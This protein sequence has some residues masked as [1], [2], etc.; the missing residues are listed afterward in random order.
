MARSRKDRQET[1]AALLGT[2]PPPPR[3]EPDPSPVEA[4]TPA[5]VEPTAVEEAEPAQV[6]E[7]PQVTVEPPRS[8]PKRQR[9][10][11]PEPAPLVAPGKVR[12]LQVR[13][14]AR[15]FE[16][17]REAKDEAGD[18]HEVFFLDALDAVFDELGEHYKP[19]PV[20]RTR[21]P[22]RQRRTRRP[23]TDPLVSYPLRL[24]G[25]EIGVLEERRVEL[26]TVPSLADMVTTVVMLRL[27][28]LGR[29]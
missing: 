13:I 7:P 20:R 1:M 29:L 16:L 8:E 21:V 19:R 17:A 14:P 28:Q 24:T 26:G 15:L 22:V 2:V 4:E 27:R 18:T 9:Q 12:L 11:A 6:P 25:E 23:T 5:A 10:P 3:R